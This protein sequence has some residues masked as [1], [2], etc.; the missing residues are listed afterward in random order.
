ML[1]SISFLPACLHT[2]FFSGHKLF[3]TCKESS[4]NQIT[5]TDKSD[6]VTS[7]EENIE[8]C[9][10]VTLDEDVTRLL[11]TRLTSNFTSLE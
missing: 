10:V 9:H 5:R 6:Q 7:E 1:V 3:T 4:A 8:L 11:D 2:S